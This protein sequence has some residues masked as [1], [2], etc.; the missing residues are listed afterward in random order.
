MMF[1]SANSGA[2]DWLLPDLS[3]RITRLT[4]T[5]YELYWLSNPYGLFSQVVRRRREYKIVGSNPTRAPTNMGT[6]AKW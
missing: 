2:H 3:V 6:L 5:V 4:T 1:R